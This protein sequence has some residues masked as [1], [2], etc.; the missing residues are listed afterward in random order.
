[1]EQFHSSAA[2]SCSTG[3]EIPALYGALKYVTLSSTEFFLQPFESNLKL[4][5]LP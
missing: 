5:I 2:Y 3:Q 4:H 1:M